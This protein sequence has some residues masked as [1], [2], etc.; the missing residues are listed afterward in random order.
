MQGWKIQLT[1]LLIQ[2]KCDFQEFLIK[3]NTYHPPFSS[4]KCVSVP[5]SFW[6]LSAVRAWGMSINGG[7]R[8]CSLCV[9][10]LR[11]IKCFILSYF[12]YSVLVPTWA[13]RHVHA[14]HVRIHTYICTREF[15]GHSHWGGT[16]ANT[17]RM[18][19]SEVGD[20]YQI[21]RLKKM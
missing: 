6:C 10:V 9:R 5:S 3:I 18:R 11:D 7:A 13:T 16:G 8:V 19:V 17:V 2:T 14:T 1:T 12:C 4:A 20:R 21:E 15:A